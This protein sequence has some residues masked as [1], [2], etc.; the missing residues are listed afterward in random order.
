L[1]WGQEKPDTSEIDYYQM[2]IDAAVQDYKDLKP[3]FGRITSDIWFRNPLKNQPMATNTLFETGYKYQ[4]SK[5]KGQESVTLLGCF[6][7][8]AVAMPLIIGSLIPSPLI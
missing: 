8:I 3:T 5:Y 2:G 6:I 7:A 4:M 1:A